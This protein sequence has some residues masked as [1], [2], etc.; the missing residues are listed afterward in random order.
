MRIALF[1]APAHPSCPRVMAEDDISC[2][3]SMYTRVS[4]WI[5]VEFP[6]L[7]PENYLQ[8]QRNILAAEEEELRARLAT[9]SAER[10]R[11]E[12]REGAQS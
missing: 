3:L 7:P 6:P 5:E 11:L 8:K 12:T 1:H 2:Q 9:V 4:E 10:T